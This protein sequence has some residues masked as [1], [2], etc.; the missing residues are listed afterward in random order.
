MVI[1]GGIDLLKINTVNDSIEATA[2][3]HWYGGFGLPYVHADQHFLITIKDAG[4]NYAV[5]AANDGGIHYSPN[6]GLDWEDKNNNYNVTQYYD[7]DR[8]PF[9]DQFIAGSQ[10]NGTNLSPAG[11]IYS[12]A[13]EEV[14]GGDGFDC[15]WDKENPNV[16]YG[17]LYSSYI[18]KSVNGGLTFNQIN[19]SE[20]P[21]SDFFHTPFEM[22]PHNSQKIFTASGLNTV[23]YSCLLYTS[24]SPRD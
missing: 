3:S 14:I 9:R 1:V 10:D 12:N 16:V 19:G 6:K 5:I 7:G 18:Y 15:A 20:I 24:P 23:Y 22:D 17:T 2:L 4:D 21:E 8:H 13:W 11:T